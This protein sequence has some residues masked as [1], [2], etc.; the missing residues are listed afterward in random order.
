[1]TSTD[2]VSYKSVHEW[3]LMDVLP[4]GNWVANGFVNTQYNKSSF[5]ETV[6]CLEDV[7]RMACKYGVSNPLLGVVNSQCE[8]DHMMKETQLRSQDI[9]PLDI[10]EWI[11]KRYTN[12]LCYLSDKHI[13]DAHI[14]ELIEHGLVRKIVL[15]DESCLSTPFPE[16][17]RA[18]MSRTHTKITHM[19][20]KLP[21]KV[22]ETDEVEEYLLPCTVHS[23]IGVLC[24]K[25]QLEMWRKDK[26]VR[27]IRCGQEMLY[28][29]NDVKEM[30]DK[31][32]FYDVVFV[33]SVE[34]NTHDHVKTNYPT[35]SVLCKTAIIDTV[36]SMIKLGAVRRFFVRSLNEITSTEIPHLLEKYKVE[37]IV[38]NL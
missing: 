37:L 24:T 27:A 31:R 20:D 11:R 1:M 13:R 16:K 22:C 28:H 23:T 38:L 30:C 7:I 2:F 33:K 5:R 9:Y 10:P 17:V 18:A 26:Q 14:F 29:A 25:E 6:Y 34:D 8:K 36:I 15:Y 19:R 35:K 21:N 12:D 4:I 32:T 3:F